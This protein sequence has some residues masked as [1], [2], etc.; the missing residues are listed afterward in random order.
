MGIEGRGELKSLG[1]LGGELIQPSSPS[2]GN[3]HIPA[4]PLH[5]LSPPPLGTL[6]TVIFHHTSTPAT[7]RH[8]CQEHE[9]SSR[10]TTSATL[11]HGRQGDESSSR[12]T[13]P[14]NFP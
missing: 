1:F 11:L 8:G 2:Q 13:T 10:S 5:T 3:P 7:L 12:I 6:G 4:L 9:S 14:T